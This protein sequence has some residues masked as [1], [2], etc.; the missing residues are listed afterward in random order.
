MWLI[1]ATG[2]LQN[3]SSDRKP[4]QRYR[5]VKPRLGEARAGRCAVKWA[6]G[7]RLASSSTEE[8]GVWCLALLR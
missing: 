3:E 4:G 6:W 5:G 7:G 2:R 1:Y 8:T